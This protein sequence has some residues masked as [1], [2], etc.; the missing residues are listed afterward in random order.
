M[1]KK[2][3]GQGLVE[4]ALIL[5]VILLLFCIIIES[6]RL[7]HAYT[8]VQ[9][10]AREGARYAVTGQGKEDR[11]DNIMQVARGAA[12]SLMV[13]GSKVWLGG[14]DVPS[15]RED[16]GALMIWVVGPDGYDDPGG[17]GER[18]RVIVEHNMPIITPL[19]MPIAS[20]IKVIGQAEMI[21]EGFGATGASHGGVLP[22]TLPAVTPGPTPTASP[23]P[24]K[25][26]TPTASPTL[27]PTDTPTPSPT[28]TL[29]PLYLDE[30]LYEGDPEICGG[31]EPG[32]QVI[33]RDLNARITF[34]PP[35]TIDSNER[36]CYT[37]QGGEALVG[38]HTIV[39]IGY[40]QLAYTV[41]VGNTPTPTVV[42]SPTATPE[43]PF[44]ALAAVCGDAG[45]QVT[46]YGY[47]W[48]NKDTRLEWKTTSSPGGGTVFDP[49]G[50]FKISDTW[51]Q[52][53]TIPFGQS[54]VYIYAAYKETGNTYNAYS[55]VA[56]FDIPCPTP[57]LT[58]TPGRADVI[59]SSLS[60]SGTICVNAPVVF[61]V[62]VHNQG[63]GPVNSLFWNDLFIDPQVSEVNFHNL[64]LQLGSESNVDWAGVSSLLPGDSLTITLNHSAGFTAT[65]TYPIYALADTL[66]QVNEPDDPNDDNNVSPL[67]SAEVVSCTVTPTPTPEAGCEVP[68]Q[69]DFSLPN[70]TDEDIGETAW[71]VDTSSATDF[72]TFSVQNGRFDAEDTDGV[73][74]WLSEVIDITC[75]DTVDVSVDIA[76]GGRL[77]SSDYLDL[78]YKLNGGSEVRFAHRQD[79]F[80][81]QTVEATGLSGNTIQ[82]II[83]A[84]TN[85]NDEHH[86]WD[87]INI[88]GSGPPPT[89][90]PSPTPELFGSI[91]GATWIWVGGDWT[92]PQGRVTVKCWHGGELIATT[93][94]EGGYYQLTDIP[95]D[96]GYKVTGEIQVDGVTYY[97][98]RV[99]VTVEDGQDTPYIDL[100]LVPPF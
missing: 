55:N 22:P 24:S 82:I 86:Y 10:A 72:D 70:G 67:Y 65:G 98:E 28:P 21:N 36:F 19:V 97:D 18:V 20:K 59:I 44:I 89:L 6:G 53:V 57:T 34:D 68:W 74:V 32:Q 87:N 76:E 30:P 83:R 92:V 38:G 66:N 85:S 39:A 47:N 64:F 48:P 23:V 1:S 14:A 8:T 77:E 7:L 26:P 50:E 5:P 94:S 41:V 91:S 12:G 43:T 58:P 49:P 4:F 17:P 96:T 35:V 80:S 78:Y 16:A 60:V 27:T 88:T 29:I 33:L 90:T 46:V 79:D 52:D 84:Y 25:T 71:S 31:G 73:A 93:Y 40:G 3:R 42:V 45:S 100:L 11:L 62:T 61:D 75:A 37:L 15:F 56:A 99:N 2:K 63:D 54:R 9:H 81:A 69:E 51:S 13:D 95:A